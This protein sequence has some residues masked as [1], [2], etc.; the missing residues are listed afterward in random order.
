MKQNSSRGRAISDGA[1]E[2]H[3]ACGR[4]DRKTGIRQLI[5]IDLW[6]IS[7]VT[8]PMLPEARVEA[9]KGG[10]MLLAAIQRATAAM[11]T[12]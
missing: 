6:E 8:F 2:I 3:T 11:R 9:V 7:V 4:T 1:H 10:A 12:A 5:E